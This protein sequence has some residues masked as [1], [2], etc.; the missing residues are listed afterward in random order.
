MRLTPVED[1][2]CLD[3]AE[4]QYWEPK[5][6][7]DALR[8]GKVGGDGWSWDTHSGQKHSKP[9]FREWQEPEDSP[10]SGWDGCIA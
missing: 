3:S 4:W 1:V 7:K 10:W 5:V 8:S 9:A 6:G 2:W